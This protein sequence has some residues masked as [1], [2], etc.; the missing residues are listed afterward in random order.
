MAIWIIRDMHI[1]LLSI[2]LSLFIP[3]KLL[4]KLNILLL[5]FL[6][7]E[8]C[9]GHAMPERVS[10]DLVKY[11][12]T[13]TQVFIPCLSVYPGSSMDTQIHIY[14]GGHVMPERVS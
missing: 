8:D 12:Y 6:D 5:G 14:P 3:A 10:W 1:N 7:C 9:G 2:V 11:G 13:G 4:S